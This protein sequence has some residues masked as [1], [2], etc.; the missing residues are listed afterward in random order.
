MIPL[1]ANASRGDQILNARSFERQGFS[2]VLEEEELTKESL[3]EAVRRLYDNRNTYMDAMRDSR[4][5]DSI[6]TIIGLVE[7]IS[8][9]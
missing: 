3:L 7:E 2:M 5:Q 9:K 6:D 8:L 1:S 4:Q